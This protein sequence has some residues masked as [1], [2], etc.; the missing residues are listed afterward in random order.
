MFRERKH[1]RTVSMTESWADKNRV[2]L[3]DGLLSPLTKRAESLQ[4]ESF[5]VIFFP[6]KI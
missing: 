5:Y 4:P 3:S 6:L 1:K 2:R